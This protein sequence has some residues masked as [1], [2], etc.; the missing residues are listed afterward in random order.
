M[1][2]RK[3]EVMAIIEDFREWQPDVWF[4]KR[5]LQA[6]PP[7][8]LKEL[9]RA[10]RPLSAELHERVH[11]WLFAG[12]KQPFH[13]LRATGWMRRLLRGKYALPATASADQRESHMRE[14]LAWPLSDVVLL[15]YQQP[16]TYAT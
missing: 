14:K 15:V 12:I 16:T 5:F 11:E 2:G 4:D 1:L 10:I 8:A 9:L 7:S 6:V 3:W 13:F